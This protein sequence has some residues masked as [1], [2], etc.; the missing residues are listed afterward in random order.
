MYLTTMVYLVW[1]DIGNKKLN[2]QYAFFL[3]VWTQGFMTAKQVLYHFSRTSSPYAIFI[4]Q[5]WGLNLGPTPW[6]TPPALF[7]EG[8]FFEIG[9]PELFV[10]VGFEPQSS[11]VTRITGMSH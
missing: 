8:F 9:S 6:V 2:E 10:W 4:L 11:W 5:Y 7:C 1:I 3:L